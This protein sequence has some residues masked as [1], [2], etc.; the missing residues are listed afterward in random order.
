MQNKQFIVNSFYCEEDKQYGIDGET[1]LIP[2]PEAFQ[3]G[4]IILNGFEHCKPLFV[5]F[6]ESFD[7]QNSC[8]VHHV[9]IATNNANDFM[10]RKYL[11]PGTRY[12]KMPLADDLKSSYAVKFVENT[13][14]LGGWKDPNKCLLL[15]PATL[16]S[17]E[18]EA[19][20]WT[21]IWEGYDKAFSKNEGEYYWSIHRG[22]YDKVKGVRDDS[23]YLDIHRVKKSELR[24]GR[25]ESTFTGT[26]ENID[27]LR[28][29]LKIMAQ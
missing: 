22:R 17:S 19:E 29:V 26:I 24:D 14:W 15:P 1:F 4:D 28:T 21:R 20:G 11:I 18:I 8:Y 3:K 6:V 5:E 13:P 10:K 25:D 7:T 2:F 23:L 16:L 12:W 9:T 27:Q